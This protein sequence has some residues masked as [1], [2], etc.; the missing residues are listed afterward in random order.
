MYNNEEAKTFWLIF[1]ISYYD[2]VK[3]VIIISYGVHIIYGEG[4]L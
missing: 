3:L 1:Y 2:E 4:L